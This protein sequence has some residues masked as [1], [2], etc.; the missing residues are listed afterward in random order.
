MLGLAGGTVGSLAGGLVGGL[1]DLGI[2]EPTAQLYD[3]AI[4]AGDV[5]VAVSSTEEGSA[6]VRAI[7][8]AHGATDIVTVQQ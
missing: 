7:L 8:V 4:R 5:L 2:N 6:V 1:V 3:K